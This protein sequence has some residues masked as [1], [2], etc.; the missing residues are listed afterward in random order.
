MWIPRR[1]STLRNPRAAVVV[2]ADHHDLRRGD[3]S[4]KFR[5]EAVEELHRFAGGVHLII[6]IAGDDDGVGARLLGSP[7]DLVEDVLLILQK[8]PVDELQADVQ[9]R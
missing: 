6:D 7:H 4:R 8:V 2:A 3:R 1:C 9:V 5:N